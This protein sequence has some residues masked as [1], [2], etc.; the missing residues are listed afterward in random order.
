MASI[1]VPHSYR[2]R[3][4]NLDMKQLDNKSRSYRFKHKCEYE[5]AYIPDEFEREEWEEKVI[6]ESVV[7]EITL[8][9]MTDK[10]QESVD[11]L[12]MIVNRLHKKEQTK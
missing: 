2:E 6:I 8:E 3:N 1:M 5:F 7:A 9:Q 10:V 12:V 4:W 11:Q